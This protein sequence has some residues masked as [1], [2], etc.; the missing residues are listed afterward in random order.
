MIEEVNFSCVKSFLTASIGL[1]RLTVLVGP[2]AAGK[3]SVLEGI[4][5]IC[6]VSE[7]LLRRNQALK[8]VDLARRL[9]SRH[10]R[11]EFR[12]EMFGNQSGLRARAWSERLA[13]APPSE[14]EDGLWKS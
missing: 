2:N 9:G 6:Q 12:L 3:S 11:G 1:G 13:N 8:I 10:G 7:A 5:A 4:Q 14:A